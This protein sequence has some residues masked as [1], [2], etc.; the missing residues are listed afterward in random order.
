[1][2]VNRVNSFSFTGMLQS[3]PKV[4]ESKI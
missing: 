3:A 2:L 1:M 4:Y